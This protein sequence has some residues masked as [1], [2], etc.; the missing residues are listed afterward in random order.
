MKEY[1]TLQEI[2]ARMLEIIKDIAK[3]AIENNLKFVLTGG[4]ALGA[5]RHQGFIPWDDDADLALPREQ[6]EFFLANYQP[7]I[8]DV[9]LLWHTTDREWN[10]PYARIADT[11][12][13]PEIIYAQVKNGIFV[14]VFPI[15]HMSDNKFMQ[16]V[17]YYQLK[18]IDILRNMVRKQHWNPN[19]PG[20]KIKKLIAPIAK[21]KSVGFY[22]KLMNAKAYQIN[23]K[24]QS[25]KTAGLLTVIGVNGMR[26]FG[27]A[28]WYTSTIWVPFC[29]TKLP[30][31]KQYDAYLTKMYG[32]YL[33]EPPVE[34]RK[35]HWNIYRL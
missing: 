19:E 10:Y 32:D 29:D 4:S 22:A 8:K 30:I 3:F 5:V 28:K 14:D 20:L 7:K 9:E 13:A 16:K 27:V 15:D 33:Q 12:T 35:H 23:K 34:S 6:Y 18:T 17:E 11:L 1:L 2:Q 31:V 24:H 21:L 25:S 26:E